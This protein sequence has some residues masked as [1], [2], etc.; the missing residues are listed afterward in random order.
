MLKGINQSIVNRSIVG[1][2][3]CKC[4]NGNGVSGGS[5]GS[6]V[7]GGKITVEFTIYGVEETS[8]DP[9]I[10]RHVICVKKED[11][12][13]AFNAILSMDLGKYSFYYVDAYI[14]YLSYNYSAISKKN[15]AMIIYNYSDGM[16]VI[17]ID[18]DPTNI[19]ILMDKNNNVDYHES[20]LCN[21]SISDNVPD[22]AKEEEI[23]KLT[24]YYREI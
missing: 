16:K 20:H 17:A 18:S 15:C 13:K 12:E 10:T 21:Q 23:H 6:G 4:I 8:G 3:N 14:D 11:A 22:T 2:V 9:P 5:N 24:L 19:I 1:G 7:N